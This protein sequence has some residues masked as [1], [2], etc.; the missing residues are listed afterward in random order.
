LLADVGVRNVIDSAHIIWDDARP[1]QMHLWPEGDR[2]GATPPLHLWNTTSPV[3]TYTV[4]GLLVNNHLLYSRAGRGEWATHFR[5][6][7]LVRQAAEASRADAE[8][9]RY[10]YGDERDARRIC[11]GCAVA[12][13]HFP[14]C[15]EHADQGPPDWWFEPIRVEAVDTI[16]AQLN[17]DKAFTSLNRLEAAAAKAYREC[18]GNWLARRLKAEGEATLRRLFGLDLRDLGRSARPGV[19]TEYDELERATTRAAKRTP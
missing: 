18:A 5:A 9:P 10:T 1:R 3:R 14:E 7:E 17:R 2:W 13:S 8:P 4:C 19:S 11:P 12:S 15:A 16:A 6:L